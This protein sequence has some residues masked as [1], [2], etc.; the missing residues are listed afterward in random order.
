MPFPA[1]DGN[2]LNADFGHKSLSVLWTDRADEVISGDD[3]IAT[4][5]Q[6]LKAAL[7]VQ[8][9]PVTLNHADAAFQV[10]ENE[11]SRHF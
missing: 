9:E 2:A 3:M 7:E 11:V 10:L 5:G 6:L 1:P 4:L 8:N